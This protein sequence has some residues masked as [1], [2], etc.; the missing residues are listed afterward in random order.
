MSNTSSIYNSSRLNSYSSFNSKYLNDF[1]YSNNNDSG[2]TKH[3]L[4]GYA[5]APNMYTENTSHDANGNP[6]IDVDYNNPK[7]MEVGGEEIVESCEVD[8]MVTQEQDDSEPF[9]PYVFIKHLPPLTPAMRARCPA[10]PRK[11]RSSPEFSL[12]LDLVR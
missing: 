4:V 10:L 7:Y 2:E 9:D 5:G 11:T 3:D 1:E 8:T 6:E 12:V